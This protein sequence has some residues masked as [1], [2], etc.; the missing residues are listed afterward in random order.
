MDRVKELG[1]ASVPFQ[2]DVHAMIFS[3]DAPA[4][5]ATLHREF[6]RRRVNAI[7]RRKE[8]FNVSLDE[9]KNTVVKL[10]GKETEFK[11]TA[12][13]EEYFETLRLLGS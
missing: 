6:D 10:S 8:F 7:N 4:M 11:M 1:D 2:F 5:E 3:E 13:A 9:I 12:L